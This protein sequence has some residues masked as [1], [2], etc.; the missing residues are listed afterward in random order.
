MPL[1]LPNHLSRSVNSRAL[2]IAVR[3][4]SLI[5][6]GLA[7]VNI[8]LSNDHQRSDVWPWLTLLALVPMSTLLIVLSR[9]RAVGL[10]VA[11]LLVGTICTYF[12]VVTLFIETPSYR[13]TSVFIVTLPVVAMTMVGGT[14]TGAI[15]G[16]L[17]ATMGFVLAE[18]AVVLG[19]LTTE[20]VFRPDAISLSAYLLLV[21]VLVF[22]SLTR[23]ARTRARSA[24]HRA[25]RDARL[26]ELRRELLAGSTADL[27][28]TVLSDLVAVAA[29]EPGE[30]SPRLRARIEAD[31][32]HLTGPT[33]ADGG[34]EATGD[35]PWCDGELCRAI[36]DARSEGLVVDVSGDREV[37]AGLPDEARR[38]VGL[39]VRQCLVN[40][41]RHSGSTTAEVTLSGSGDAVS[42]MV[43]DAGSGFAGPPGSDRLGLR[44]S[45]H[46]RIHRI[47]G[48]VT[49]YSS[50]A[51]GT[52]VIIVV[53]LL[54]MV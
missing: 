13:D 4:S 36:E 17:W 27:H 48:T 14:G 12:Y 5:C 20:R 38:A 53:P 52:T 25:V 47:G 31:L 54:E 41:L 51:V 9:R 2:A 3:W 42:V 6:L 45:V 46:D 29:S 8:L 37:L 30:L 21:G 40:V 15:A 16:I 7:M 22:D 1:G 24:I 35:D 28:D 33:A 43:V 32:G 49:I 18:L 11:Y 26:V 50:E 44:Q 34:E 10:I 39:A 23:R 19:A